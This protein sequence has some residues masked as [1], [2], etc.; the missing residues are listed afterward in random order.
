MSC[1]GEPLV[2]RTVRTHASVNISH[3]KCKNKCV[4]HVHIAYQLISAEIYLLAA[5]SA[6]AQKYHVRYMRVGQHIFC[7]TLCVPADI[8]VG[9]LLAIQPTYIISC[10]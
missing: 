4:K 3:Y 5:Y 8:Y 2:F 1:H 7:F 9:M 6:L 10:I